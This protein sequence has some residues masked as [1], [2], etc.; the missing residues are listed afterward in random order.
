MTSLSGDGA[1]PQR[2]RT[3]RFR[4]REQLDSDGGRTGPAAV[5][6]PDRPAS[7]RHGAAERRFLRAEPRGS[8][9]PPAPSPSRRP[10]VGSRLRRTGRAVR[11]GS[12]ALGHRVLTARL[13]PAARGDACRRAPAPLPGLRLRG[14][15]GP[16]RG[17]ARAA[18]APLRSVRAFLES[19][20]RGLAAA[21]RWGSG[22]SGRAARPGDGAGELAG[23]E[24]LRGRL[25]VALQAAVARPALCGAGR[26]YVRAGT[27]LLETAQSSAARWRDACELAAWWYLNAFRIPKP[28]SK[29][30]RGDG[31]GQDVLEMLACDRK[32]Q[33]GR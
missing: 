28:K 22:A 2:R 20:E 15:G 16:Q 7:P 23:D 8:A 5:P 17:R 26:F 10:R 24:R 32:S 21:G 6:S 29:L 1:S 13:R 30:I 31:A 33:C 3:A 18:P 4:L 9:I 12:F 11:A 14:R 27:F 25:D 19:G